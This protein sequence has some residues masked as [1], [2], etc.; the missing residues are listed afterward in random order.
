MTRGHPS[1]L[2]NYTFINFIN[3]C[4]VLKLCPDKVEISGNG[5]TDKLQA[6]G[7]M[8]SCPGHKQGPQGM[9]VYTYTTYTKYMY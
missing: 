8:P 1:K 4:D 9:Y 5:I 7:G 2:Y 3:L 6:D